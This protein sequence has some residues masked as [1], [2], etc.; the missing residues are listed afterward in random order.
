MTLRHLI[1]PCLLAAS[2]ALPVQAAEDPARFL[3]TTALMNK[4][5]A[6]EPDLKKLEKDDDDDADYGKDGASVEEV[7]A[8]INKRPDAVAALKKHGITP[9]EYA[10]AMFASLHAG[11]FVAMEPMMDK[12]K[13]DEAVAK[14]TREQQA[15]IALFRTLY[16]QPQKKK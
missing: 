12:K 10:L 9:R 8:T 11:M 14:Y 2:F 5:K 6:A 16:P 1:L 4:M 13:K 3:L 15:N 7:I